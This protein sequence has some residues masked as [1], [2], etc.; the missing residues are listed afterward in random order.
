MSKVEE[1]LQELVLREREVELQEERLARQAEELTLDERVRQAERLGR[2]LERERC[3][4][5]LDAQL[6]AFISG[7]MNSLVL[8]A[9]RRQIN[10]E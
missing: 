8:K 7:G 6:D 10:G 5:L 4:A 1:A 3:L 9:L 2:D